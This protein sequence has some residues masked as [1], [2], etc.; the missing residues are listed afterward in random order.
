MWAEVVNT[1]ILV[2]GTSGLEDLRFSGAV[3][4]IGADAVKLQAYTCRA[5]PCI[6][7]S[8]IALDLSAT[9]AFTCSHYC[10]IS[11]SS[12]Y[13]TEVR[14]GFGKHPVRCGAVVSG[15]VRI[16]AYP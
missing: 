12:R 7:R 5:R 3:I 13:A 8:S 6:G 10:K 14:E 15:A 11:V 2:L 9:A 4:A 16:G 1:Y